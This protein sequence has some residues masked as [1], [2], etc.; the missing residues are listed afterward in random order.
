MYEKYRKYKAKYLEKR[1]EISN[2]SELSDVSD[3]VQ[4]VPAPEQ[5]PTPEPE[6]EQVPEPVPEQVPQQ[7]KQV[8]NNKP[9]ILKNGQVYQKYDYSRVLNYAKEHSK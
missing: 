6:P 7:F 1:L 3:D 2:N 5:V 4:E 8:V 9:I